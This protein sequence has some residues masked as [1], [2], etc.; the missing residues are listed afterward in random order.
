MQSLKRS[1]SGKPDDDAQKDYKTLYI[2]RSSLVTLCIIKNALLMIPQPLCDA[3][4]IILCVLFADVLFSL[5]G[6]SESA[7]SD[8][9]HCAT[10]SKDML[11]HVQT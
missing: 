9:S 8:V 1:T 11:L 7:I 5:A 10:S 2:K 6:G 4:L 3:C